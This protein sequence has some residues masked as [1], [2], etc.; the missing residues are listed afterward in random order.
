MGTTHRGIRGSALALAGAVLFVLPVA[1]A[2]AAAPEP[3]IHVEPGG[4][5]PGQTVT[6]RLDD[7]PAPTA[8]VSVCGNS[9]NRGSQDCEQRGAQGV[10]VA[11]RGS[12]FVSFAVTTP[13]VGC[14]CVVRA[15]SATP[16]LVRTTTIELDGVPVVAPILATGPARSS[17]L[18]VSTEVVGGDDSWPASWAG[19]FGGPAGRRLRLRLTNTGVATISGMSVAASVGRDDTTGRPIASRKA[20]ALAPHTTETVEVPFRLDAPAWG[21]YQ[22]FGHVYG[23]DRPVSFVT[24]THSSPWAW[25]VVLPLA[26][27]LVAQVIRRRDRAHVRVMASSA[28]IRVVPAVVPAAEPAPTA[29]IRLPVA[30]AASAPVPLAAE[31]VIDLTPLSERSPDVVVLDEGRSQVPAYDPH[32]RPEPTVAP[33]SDLAS[34]T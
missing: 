31:R 3:A 29:P 5:A 11:A 18:Q 7:W 14:P 12:T 10:A 34:V 25:E 2:S 23:L 8:T 32:E 20:A 21:D 1:H 27:L 9:A 22:V 33:E 15:E 6:V 28:P 17:D 24:S 16:G 13:P 19:A 26:L 4:A 30:P